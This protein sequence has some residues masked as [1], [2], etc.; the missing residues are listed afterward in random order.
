[1]VPINLV[2]IVDTTKHK[3]EI[4]GLFQEYDL[5]PQEKTLPNGQSIHLC[6]SEDPKCK[7]DRW[8][9]KLKSCRSEVSIR[10]NT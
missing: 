8:S 3:W 6:I 7:R 4:I 2:K 9:C 10:P 1:M 5:V